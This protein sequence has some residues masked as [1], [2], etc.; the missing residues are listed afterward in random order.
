MAQQGCVDK[1]PSG[2]GFNVD[3]TYLL[4]KRAT[5][6]L[7]EFTAKVLP[8]GDVVPSFM[9]ALL[10][11]LLVET[12]SKPQGFPGTVLSEKTGT[13]KGTAPSGQHCR[14]VRQKGSHGAGYD[15]HE[16]DENFDGIGNGG[17]VS[18]RGSSR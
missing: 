15:K 4:C 11:A 12:F 10:C 8:V 3:H 14:H 7:R 2:Y 5:R 17:G 18:V 13:S 9:P 1:G 6:R 16:N